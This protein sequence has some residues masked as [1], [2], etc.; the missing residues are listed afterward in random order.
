MSSMNG[1][2]HPTQ[3]QQH[4]MQSGD[5]LLRALGRH[6]LR[7]EQRHKLYGRLILL[8]QRLPLLILLL[9]GL[10]ITITIVFHGC[11]YVLEVSYPCSRLGLL[12]KD[13]HEL[14]LG[15]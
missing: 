7:E 15:L 1:K 8:L 10:G 12:T 11:V 13:A 5:H 4:A 14:A 3:L 2:P 6:G 9:D